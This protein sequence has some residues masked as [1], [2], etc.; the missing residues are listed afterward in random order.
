MSRPGLRIALIVSVILNVFAVGMIAGGLYRWSRAEPPRVFAVPHRGR[1]RAAGDALAPDQRRTYRRALRQTARESRPLVEQARAARL[2]AAMAF[3][4]PEF[5]RNA[6]TTALDQA[7]AAD[8]ALRMRA[9]RAVVDAAATLPVD[10][11]G[12]LAEGLGRNGPLRQSRRGARR[13]RA[14]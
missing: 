1:L 14:Q 7:R 12:L 3:T 8:F 5:D 2:R 13:D 6:V 9:E 10:Q 4:A 11:R